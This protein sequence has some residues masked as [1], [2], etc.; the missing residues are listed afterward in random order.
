M[1][2]KTRVS[3]LFREV[4]EELRRD[5]AV[6]LWK[7][8]GSYVL[9]AAVAL[10]VGTGAYVAWRDYN[11]NQAEMFGERFFAAASQSS[12][13]GGD[14]AATFDEF[15][16]SAPSG[17][18]ALAR[19]REAALRAEAG[20]ADAALKIYDQLADDGGAPQEFRDVAK[21]LAALHRVARIE[22]GELDRQLAP[23]RASDS[24]WRFSA[25]EIAALAVARA[26]DAGKARELYA[27]IADDPAAPAGLRAR[28]AEMIA[29]LGT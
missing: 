17:Y 26:G 2:G 9:G 16:R 23:L 20:D 19:L 29:T 21:L 14:K 1:H 12:Q 6:E 28:A 13:S 24:P 5:R 11:R 27:Q 25:M 7:R 8:Y 3:D 18:A 22:P 10:V 15:A 4:D